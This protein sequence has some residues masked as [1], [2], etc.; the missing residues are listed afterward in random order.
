MYYFKSLFDL[1]YQR[2]K[3]QALVYFFFVFLFGIFATGLVA[4]P[5]IAMQHMMGGGLHL[6]P[7]LVYILVMNIS[8]V[9]ALLIFYHKG[10]S[11]FPWFLVAMSTPFLSLHAPS[12]AAIV[13]GFVPIVILSMLKS[14]R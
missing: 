14:R 1:N 5:I 13:A 6:H 8:T 12:Y 9:W 10:L 11:Y 4:L 7:L 3:G 2:S